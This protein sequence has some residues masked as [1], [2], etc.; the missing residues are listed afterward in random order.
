MVLIPI[1]MMR[2]IKRQPAQIKEP[3]ELLN[4]QSLLHGAKCI[5]CVSD[6]S[7]NSLHYIPIAIHNTSSSSESTFTPRG[8]R[9]L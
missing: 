4:F 1:T 2:G 3:T 5:G 8:V 7:G 6:I 9:L